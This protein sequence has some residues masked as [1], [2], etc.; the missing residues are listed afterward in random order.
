VPLTNLGGAGDIKYKLS[1]LEEGDTSAD[2]ATSARKL[3][4]DLIEASRKLPFFVFVVHPA[5]QYG[6]GGIGAN[7]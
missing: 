4:E 5:F 7:S 2:G 3:T 6:C 1:Y